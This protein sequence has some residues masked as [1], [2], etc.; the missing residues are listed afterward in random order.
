[1]IDKTKRRRMAVTATIFM[2]GVWLCLIMARYSTDLYY[3][4][5][6]GRNILANGPDGV[7]RFTWETGFYI[8]VQN[9]LVCTALAL[10]ER[11][12]PLFAQHMVYMPI[13]IVTY[14]SLAKYVERR[15]GSTEIGYGSVIA[16]L[17]L[18]DRFFSEMR[19]ENI[20]TLLVVLSAACFESYRATEKKR[21]L[22]LQPVL[23]V[24]EMNMH[25][26]MWFVHF[27]VLAAYAVPPLVPGLYGDSRAVR[28]KD[29][30]ACGAAMAAAMLLNPYGAE[31]ILYLPR[32]L[33]FF[34]SNPVS[35]QASPRFTTTI[36]AVLVFFWVAIAAMLKK[37]AIRSS[38]LHI[39]AGFTLL[40]CIREHGT[41]FMPVAGA[42]LI[43]AVLESRTDKGRDFP[44]PER[45][46]ALIQ[47]L[48]AVLGVGL[49]IF[50]LAVAPGRLEPRTQA[51]AEYI[52][53]RQA[54]TGTAMNVIADPQSGSCLEYG[55][56]RGVYM[57]GRVEA[58]SGAINGKDDMW[59]DQKLFK[60]GVLVTHGDKRYT[61][62]E[63]YIERNDIWFIVD[64]SFSLRYPYL[65]SWAESSG[66]WRAIRDNGSSG[67]TLWERIS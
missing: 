2:T 17:I 43:C 66:D 58:L 35:E 44:V 6:E 9:W 27:C 10:C 67:L 33:L 42:V 8:P 36:G 18:T 19:P 16:L 12:H 28:P 13:A 11:I 5:A 20:S 53:E 1:M 64:E 15:T 54:E 38:D 26:T 39:C 49:G 40:T 46:M 37:K 23:M 4:L 51:I 32:T 60:D 34:R 56:V 29:A 45:D 21:Y 63:D 47:A 62:L 22:A 59:A 3:M 7:N 52:L 55:G 30:A 24:L 50:G 57:D 41:T 25:A 48:L 65:V 61:G 31:M 14:L